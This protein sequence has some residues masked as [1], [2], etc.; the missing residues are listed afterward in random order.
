VLPVNRQQFSSIIAGYYSNC[1]DS[2]LWLARLL[3]LFLAFGYRGR[4]RHQRCG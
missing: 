3:T 2:I 1:I 4:S